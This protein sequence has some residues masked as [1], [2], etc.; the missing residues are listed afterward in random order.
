MIR[1]P[2]RP[3][4]RILDA[5]AR[6]ENPDAIEREN[7]RLRQ[8]AQRDRARLR[9][10]LRITVVALLF[11]LGFAWIG[12]R[13]ALLAAAGTETPQTTRTGSGI[14]SARADIVDRTGRLL[15]TNIATQ[16]LYAQP[17]HM[18][19]PVAAARGLVAIFP[20][21]NE[22]RLRTWFTDPAR[23][24]IWLRRQLSPEQRQMVQDLGEPGLLFGDRALRVYPNGRLAAHVLGGTR[25]GD[26]DVR[27]AEIVG[28]A[29]VELALQAELTD[30]ARTHRSVR[31]SLDLT[32]QAAT[33]EVLAGGMRLMNA[34]GAAAV[35]LD[36]RT[37]EVIAMAS[38]PD[39]DPN[40]RPAP[41][42]EGDP[43]HSPIFNRAVLGLY[44]LGSVAKTFTIAQALELGI[45]T[46]ATMVDTTTPMRWGR[47]SI[48]DFRPAGPRLSVTDVLVRSSNVGTAR[49][50]LQIG[51]ERQ[52]AFLASLGLLSILP[53]ELPE[54]NRARPLFAAQ[55]SDISTITI[56]YGHGLSY[57]PLHLAAAYA[58]LVNGGTRVTPTLLHRPEPQLGERVISEATSRQMREMLRAA[59]TRGTATFADIEGYE[60]GGKT[61]TADRPN[62]QGGYYRDRVIATF[63]SVFPSS[64]PQYVLV[65]ML[66]EPVETSGTEPRRTAGWTAA[67]VAGEII[68]RIAPLL[69]VEP[70]LA[71]AIAP[72]P[73][74]GITPV[75]N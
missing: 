2:L 41:P 28:V 7:L 51:G 42:T 62:P 44:E 46:P 36:V 67:P 69:G 15:A 12:G 8:E 56:S 74:S 60:V 1:R 63:A 64:D 25:F 38:L 34:R 3:L 59:V 27:A 66:D 49:L 75:R 30:P 37:G 52:R 19:D 26:E 10:V 33:E 13:M 11:V 21:M 45:A 73:A 24:F 6:G 71:G 43:S 70:R 17:R 39:F 55:W 5:R 61:G 47:F 65:V 20:D 50:A 35:V 9:A 57:S 58:T 23:Q 29:G 54:A 16:S 18:I 40:D 31:L 68:R 48:N 72:R 22:E 32:V 4:A 14:V 53:I